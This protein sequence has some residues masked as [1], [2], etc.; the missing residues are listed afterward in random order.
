M[1]ACNPIGFSRPASIKPK[2]KVQKVVEKNAEWWERPTPR[3]S[4]CQEK[5]Q[6]QKEPEVGGKDQDRISKKPVRYPKWNL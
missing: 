2:M 4:R 6:V 3:I 5:K 1:E